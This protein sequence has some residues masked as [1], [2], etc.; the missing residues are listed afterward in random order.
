[1]YFVNKKQKKRKEFFMANLQKY[2]KSQLGHML[3]HYSRARGENGE[4]IK[5]GNQNIN[6][7]LTPKNTNL[8]ERKDGLSDYAFIQKKAADLKA[9]KRADVNLM[10]TWVIT[11]PVPILEALERKYGA[12]T[13]RKDAVVNSF[14]Q[15]CTNFVAA[16]YGHKNIIGSFA[17]LDETTPHTHIPFVPVILDTKK[18]KYKISAKECVNRLDLQ[19]FHQDLDKYIKRVWSK[20]LNQ[21]G[22]NNTGILVQKDGSDINKSNLQLQQELQKL[23][24]ENN[25]LKKKNL[26]YEKTLQKYTFTKKGITKNL[27]EWEYPNKNPK[28]IKTWDR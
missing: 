3:K 14:L 28:K 27:L 16:R 4:Y 9:L 5:F 1:M 8:R 21:L 10:C 22:L 19:T 18:K 26:A 17:H 24:K 15:N 2:N 7:N 12:D 25:F 13:E 23:R 20:E 11:V 6:P